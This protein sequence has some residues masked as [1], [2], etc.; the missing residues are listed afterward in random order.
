MKPASGCRFCGKNHFAHVCWVGLAFCFAVLAFGMPCVSY[1]ETPA[2]LAALKAKAEKGDAKAELALGN[3]YCNCEDYPSPPNHNYAEALKWFRKAA[4]QGNAEGQ[5]ELGKMYLHGLG[6]ARNASEA[7]N[8]FRKSAEQGNAEAELGIAITY[9]SSSATRDIN[10]AL[11][12]ARKSAEHGN[13][14]AEEFLG[15]TYH[16]GE[17]DVPRDYAEALK[18]LRKAV[19]HDNAD[20]QYDLGEMYEKGEGVTK[21]YG[22][23]VHLFQK[24]A[25][26]GESMAQRDLGVM[27]ATGHGVPRDIVT[28][29]M[30]VWLSSKTLPG[31][32]DNALDLIEAQLTPEQ[33]AKALQM[34]SAFKALKVH[35]RAPTY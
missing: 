9:L 35:N 23:A 3:I 8:W 11:K 10:Q 26:Q 25:A 28:G 32:S 16:Y 15:M 6:V 33:K 30:W 29:Y 17:E 4:D 20:A 27:Y 34:A 21:D 5:D 31:L 12:W 18:W 13:G 14:E 2:E 22:E 7:A 1:A 19:T 24:A